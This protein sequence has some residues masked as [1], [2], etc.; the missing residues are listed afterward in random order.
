MTEI[1]GGQE[2]FSVAEA[3]GLLG[4]PVR[5]LISGALEP[6]HKERTRDGLIVGV[7][8]INDE[9]ELLMKFEDGLHQ[10]GKCEFEDRYVAI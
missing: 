1:M 9:I 3:M 4:A 6:Y 10:A 7:I 2:S 5:Q 8:T